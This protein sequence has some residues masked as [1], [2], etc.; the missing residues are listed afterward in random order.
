MPSASFTGVQALDEHR[1]KGGR[2]DI[3]LQ[4]EG[5][6]S[7]MVAD[8]ST[9]QGAW[10]LEFFT[11]CLVGIRSREQ[12]GVRQTCSSSGT[13]FSDSLPPVRLFPKGSTT[14]LLGSKQLNT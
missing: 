10:N 14:L 3:G 8:G 2:I 7:T 6:Q 12:I 4:F 11:P 5:T 9:V 13:T 1:L